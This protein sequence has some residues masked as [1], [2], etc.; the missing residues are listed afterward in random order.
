MH[1]FGKSV[2]LIH[3]L[4]EKKKFT[5]DSLGRHAQFLVESLVLWTH[6]ELHL[7]Q[8][9]VVYSCTSWHTSS[10]CL[11]FVQCTP[12]CNTTKKVELI[13]DFVLFYLSI[14]IS[15]QRWD[16]VMSSQKIIYLW[17][18]FIL[19]YFHVIFCT[20]SFRKLWRKRQAYLLRKT[21]FFKS[22]SIW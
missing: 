22:V 5:K 4:R 17:F 15:K 16:I 18:Y 1:T 11:S 7:F 21:L 19:Y 3:F 6:S 20:S 9:T 8:C 13:C 10:L 2:E 14:V 12:R